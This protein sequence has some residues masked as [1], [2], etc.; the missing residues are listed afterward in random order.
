MSLTDGAL[1]MILYVNFKPGFNLS[2]V[3]TSLAKF[4]YELSPHT[5]T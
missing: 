5:C 1:A 3:S 4:N 2:S